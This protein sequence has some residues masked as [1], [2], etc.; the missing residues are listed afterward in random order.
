MI[1]YSTQFLDFFVRDLNK[2]KE[3]LS[4]YGNE[5]NIWKTSGQI[6]NSA[7]TLTLHLIG[8]LNHFFGA[9]LGNTGYVRQ[10]ELEFSTR[11]VARGTLIADLDKTIA[12]MQSTFARLD[13]RSLGD[14]FP[15]MKHEK[16]ET[17]GHFM[18]HLY[19]HLAYHLGQVNYHRRLLDL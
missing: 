10:R 15:I 12:M 6:S 4:A 19:G 16:H 13:N 5:A 17:T 2:L 8:N 1:D 7:G 18:I 9:T 11:D 14:T 3:E